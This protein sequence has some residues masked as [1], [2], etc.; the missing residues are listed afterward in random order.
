MVGQNL[1][2]FFSELTFSVVSR[3]RPEDKKAPGETQ[4]SEERLLCAESSGVFALLG[5]GW[6]GR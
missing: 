5:S 1:A 6:G 3:A 4:V 2:A